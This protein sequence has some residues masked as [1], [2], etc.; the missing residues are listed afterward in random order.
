MK[1]VGVQTY[2]DD[3]ASSAIAMLNAVRSP[4]N[5]RKSRG[6]PDL[7]AD[8]S[9][10]GLII[11][12]SVSFLVG[13]TFRTSE[14]GFNLTSERILSMQRPS[15][16]QAFNGFLTTYS[17]IFN[18]TS[19]KNS[20][21]SS[22]DP[23]IIGN[24]TLSVTLRSPRPSSQPS[25]QPTLQPRKR[26]SRQPTRQPVDSPSRQPVRHPT[27]QPSSHPTLNMVKIFTD[28]M[29]RLQAEYIAPQYLTTYFYH[30]VVRNLTYYSACDR[31]Q[32]FNSNLNQQLQGKTAT[33]VQYIQ[34]NTA[35]TNMSVRPTLISC[36]TAGDAQK[37]VTSLASTVLRSESVKCDSHKWTIKECGSGRAVCVDCSDPC[38][39]VALTYSMNPCGTAT[40]GSGLD[41]VISFITVDFVNDTT[42]YTTVLYSFITIFALGFIPFLVVKVRYEEKKTKSRSKNKVGAHPD[43]TRSS[44]PFYPGDASFSERNPIYPGNAAVTRPDASSYIHSATI[45]AGIVPTRVACRVTFLLAGSS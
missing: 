8:A 5:L 41:G 34:S 33:A 43:P 17:A 16:A 19:L 32:T 21:V 44:S 39:T 10:S 20:F 42:A 6:R 30:M 28:K 12:Y 38:A 11:L 9:S 18:S 3:T 4:I 26:P 22:S 15:D 36:S 45:L 23:I 24:L 1:V 35:I 40:I 13:K 27:L 29:I 31:W 14:Q 2:R 37:I 25:T 7:A